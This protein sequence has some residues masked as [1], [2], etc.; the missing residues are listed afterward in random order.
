MDSVLVSFMLVHFLENYIRMTVGLSVWHNRGQPFPYFWLC[1]Y[2]YV[3]T[4]TSKFSIVWYLIL[5]TLFSKSA[6][7][8]S[9]HINVV[10]TLS[11]VH[12]WWLQKYPSH[13]ALLYRS[14]LYYI[15]VLALYIISLYLLMQTKNYVWFPVGV[16]RKSHPLFIA[17]SQM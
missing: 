5:I 10:F 1:L 2:I 11:I 9:F 12:S 3:F 15:T 8:L 16:I 17:L 14:I 6:L 4:R 13:I 7:L